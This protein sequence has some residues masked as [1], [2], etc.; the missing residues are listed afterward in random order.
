MKK[1]LIIFYAL[2]FLFPA[3][4]GFVIN[5]DPIKE[6]GKPLGNSMK[7]IGNPLG[8]QTPHH[9]RRNKGSH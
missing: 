7:E 2:L 3:M 4:S 9:D 6:V 5:L 8:Q 1:S